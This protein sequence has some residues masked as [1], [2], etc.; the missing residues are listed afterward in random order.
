MIKNLISLSVIALMAMIAFEAYA[1]NQE[2]KRCVQ[3]TKIK[4][5]DGTQWLQVKNNCS[6]NATEFVVTVKYQSS[7][8]IIEETHEIP[9][10]AFKN[11]Y[12]EHPFE[13]TNVRIISMVSNHPNISSDD[14]DSK[15]SSDDMD[16]PPDGARDEVWM[17]YYK[18]TAKL[19]GKKIFFEKYG[20]CSVGIV[21]CMAFR[22][23]REQIPDHG[24]G[25]KCEIDLQTK[26]AYMLQSTYD[27]DVLGRTT[28]ALEKAVDSATKNEVNRKK[29]GNNVRRR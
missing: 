18:K 22:H 1:Q 24:K 7:K 15:T 29:R 21:E 28:K 27:E 4:K 16:C 23:C 8:G 17:R 5:K 20:E 13:G 12:W 19:M 9:R 25:I 3:S 2:I 14:M 11:G 10:Y 6:H 26:T